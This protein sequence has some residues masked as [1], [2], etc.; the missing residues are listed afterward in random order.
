MNYQF[1]TGKLLYQNPFTKTEDI[2]DWIQEGEVSIDF[3]EYGMTLANKLDPELCGDSAHWLFWCPQDFPDQIV[4]EWDFRPISDEGLCM[5]FC[6][7]IGRNGLDIFSDTL[8][9]RHGVYPE[10]HSGAINAL[11]LSYYRRKYASERKFNTCNLRKSFGFH[12][13]EMGA[14]P[15]PSVEN[16]ITSYHMKV[17]KYQGTVQLY[18]DD[19]CVLNW[20]DDGQTY[21]PILGKGKIG[22]RQ[23]APMK[24]LYSNLTVHEAVLVK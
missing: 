10:Y 5:F 11:H 8:P 23:M 16:V 4:V 6:S 19:L 1:T 7:A 17:I 15:I 24:A 21:G 12:L 20:Q 13:V 3:N 14:D 18:I 2:Q 22:F 9:Q